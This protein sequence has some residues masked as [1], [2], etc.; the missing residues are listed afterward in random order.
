LKSLERL[1][2]L[3]YDD[4]VPGH[5]EEPVSKEYVDKVV[6]LVEFGIEEVRDSIRAGRDAESTAWDI[7]FAGWAELFVGKDPLGLYYFNE[8]FVKPAIARAHAELSGS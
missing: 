3:D 8:W 1:R 6:R 7:T 4:I 5:G 2:E